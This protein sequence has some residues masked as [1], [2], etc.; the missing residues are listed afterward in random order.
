MSSEIVYRN[1]DPNNE[2]P[3]RRVLQFYDYILISD[4]AFDEIVTITRSW[5]F[6][7]SLK[8]KNVTFNKGF[9]INVSFHSGIIFEN[10]EV[11]GF[12][13]VYNSRFEKNIFAQGNPLISGLVIKDCNFQSDIQIENSWVSGGITLENTSVNSLSIKRLIVHKG[14]FIISRL[15][16]SAPIKI[17]NLEVD[18]ELCIEECDIKGAFDLYKINTQRLEIRLS[19]F[20]SILSISHLAGCRKLDIVS[21]ILQSR[22][23]IDDLNVEDFQFC[24][25]DLRSATEIFVQRHQENGHLLVRKRVWNIDLIENT[26]AGSLLLKLGNNELQNLRLVCR[27][28][29]TGSLQISEGTIEQLFLTGNQ[30]IGKTTFKKLVLNDID[31][32]DLDNMGTISFFEVQANVSEPSLRISNS[33]LNSTRLINVD[34]SNFWRVN[35]TNSLIDDL[36]Y[37]NVDWFETNRLNALK[38]DK[39]KNLENKLKGKRE[40]LRQLKYAAE[41]HGDRPQALKFKADEYELYRTLLD[42]EYEV[43]HSRRQKIKKGERILESEILTGQIIGEK[44]SLILGLATNNLGQNWLKPF[45]QIILI[46]V[47]VYPFFVIAYSSELTWQ[48]FGNE[49]AIKESLILMWQKLGALPQLFNPVRYLGRVFESDQPL[50]SVI[51][52]WDTAH[53]IV[54]A[55]YIYQIIAA[56]RKYFK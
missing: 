20:H 4:R 29:F 32:Q 12:A 19:E 51:Y 54:L 45:I 42:Y 53:R 18:D 55:F 5:V 11:S 2:L 43:A 34:L 47:L 1:R 31:I 27:Q 38:H 44:W 25:S 16:S 22:V 41:R 10:C 28:A 26:G 9:E 52:F 40:V 15:R 3:L 50:P 14:S 7:S 24:R 37:S 21:C 56:F 13:N 36:K 8:F 6:C 35:I 17:T 48:P 33:I 49:L 30:G 46:T 23:I 39:T